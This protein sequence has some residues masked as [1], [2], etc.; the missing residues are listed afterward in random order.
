[1]NISFSCNFCSR[2][3]R[4]DEA[5]AGRKV[6]CKECDTDLTIP[7]AG[8]VALGVADYAPRAATPQPDLYGLDDGDQ[9]PPPPRRPGMRPAPASASR[10]DWSSRP[11][12]SGTSPVAVV[13]GIVVAIAALG[14]CGALVMNFKGGVAAPAPIVAQPDFARP[15]FA[16]PPDFQPVF[17]PPNVAAPAPQPNQVAPGIHVTLSNGKSSPVYSHFGMTLPGLEFH[18]EY[19]MTGDRPPGITRYIT[20]VKGPR[21]RATSMFEFLHGSGMVGGTVTTMK[22][23]D[24]PFEMYIEAETFGRQRHKVSES[25]PLPWDNTPPPQQDIPQPPN[26]GQPPGMPNNPGNRGPGM[27]NIPRF[28]PRGRM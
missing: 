17:P 21:S 2:K 12:E 22:Q 3:Y 28:G 6:K 9:A 8:A 23:G 4:V 5:L 10:S 16:R 7:S 18:A 20:V 11:S 26:F 15:N 1:M 27:P 14:I 13:V 24:G 19:H 25:I